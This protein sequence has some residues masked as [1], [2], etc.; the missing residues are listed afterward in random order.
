MTYKDV[1]PGG[2]HAPQYLQICKKV[3]QKAA[4]LQESL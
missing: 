2:R 1:P 3:D 4:I